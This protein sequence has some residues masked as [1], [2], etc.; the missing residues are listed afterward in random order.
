MTIGSTIRQY[1]KEL[2]LTQAQLAQKVGVSVQAVSKWETGAGFPDITQIVPLARS[3][4]IST[5]KLLDYND[6]REEFEKL[7][8]D[9]VDRSHADPR[10]MR[11]VSLAALELYPEDKLFLLRAAVDEE[12]LASVAEEKRVREGHL[13]NALGYSRRLLRL[14]PDNTDAKIR[15]VRIYSQLGMDDQAVALAY[16][17]TGAHREHAL[18]YCLKG[19]ALR[20]HIQKIV[21]RK[22]TSLLSELS[23]GDLEML[24]AAERIL[25]AAIPDGN[26]QHYYEIMADI[27][28]KRFVSYRAEGKEQAACA[29]LR[30]VL[31]LARKADAE[32]NR[33]FTAPHFDLLENINPD[34]L[35]DRA[36]R[37]LLSY[38]EENIPG[39]QKEPDLAQ[40]VTEAYAYLKECNLPIREI[41]AEPDTTP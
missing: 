10:Q 33:A 2:G 8:Q 19:D 9:T 30:Q 21:D 1:R 18:K 39:W 41:I 32:K 40:I 26:Y 7:W 6:R 37:W 29:A 36:W 13:Y 5:D 14:D 3:L 34:S 16:Q 20:H 25:R 27:Y 15:M 28:L 4:G 12:E 23:D 31:E 38:V 22:L 35:P 24:D 11:E 17:C